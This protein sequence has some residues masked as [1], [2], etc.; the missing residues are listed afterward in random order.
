MGMEDVEL[1][2]EVREII[3]QRCSWRWM[4]LSMIKMMK[5]KRSVLILLQLW[6]LRRLLL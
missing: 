4:L 6:L 3:V 1:G 2:L 5:E